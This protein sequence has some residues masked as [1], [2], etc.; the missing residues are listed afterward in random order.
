MNPE[1]LELTKFAKPHLHEENKLEN[2]EFI[3]RRICRIRQLG[4][5]PA[6]MALSKTESPNRR[7]LVAG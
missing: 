7:E 6:M 3:D 5:D 4:A 1:M 2:E